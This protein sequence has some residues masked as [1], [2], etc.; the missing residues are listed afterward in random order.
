M[1]LNG[2]IKNNIIDEKKSDIIY[3]STQNKDF[4]IDFISKVLKCG[5]FKI[6]IFVEI[7]S[8]LNETNDSSLNRIELVKILKIIKTQIETSGIPI[9]VNSSSEE[10]I[11][12]FMNYHN[13]MVRIFNEHG[14]VLY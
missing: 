9:D 11:K 8:L 13:F 5:S 3:I 4:I 1:S 6:P 14:I 10:R 7:I 2:D 12:Y